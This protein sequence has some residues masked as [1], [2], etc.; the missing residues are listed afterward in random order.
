MREA[1]VTEAGFKRKDQ[2]QEKDKK[3][4]KQQ[5]LYDRGMLQK[6]LAALPVALEQDKSSKATMPNNSHASWLSNL[7]Q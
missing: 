6:F 3:Q 5:C 4:R 1:N 2:N 7:D